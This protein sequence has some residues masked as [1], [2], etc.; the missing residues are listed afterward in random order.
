MVD[1]EADVV[2]D[3]VVGDVEETVT[4]GLAEEVEEV[5]MAEVVEAIAVVEEEEVM[6]VEVTVVGD[7][8]EDTAADPPTVEVE[9][10]MAGGRSASLSRQC[11]PML[12]CRHSRSP[13]RHQNPQKMFLFLFTTFHARP[14]DTS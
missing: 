3:A 12:M 10:A 4:I 8:A 2:E 9:E 1:S 11:P 13:K 6:A 5:V 14:V 7:V